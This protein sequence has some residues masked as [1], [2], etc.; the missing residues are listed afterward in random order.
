MSFQVINAQRMRENPLDPWN[1]SEPDGNVLVAHCTCMAGLG[2]ACSHSAALV[3]SID[4]MVQMRD[5]HL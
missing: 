1:I 4:Y 5:I 3:F 2:E